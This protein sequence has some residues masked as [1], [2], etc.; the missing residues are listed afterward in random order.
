MA[1]ELAPHKAVIFIRAEVHEVLKGGEC[2]GDP[3]MKIGTFP[4]AISGKD[5]FEAERK[6]NELL[7]ELKTRCK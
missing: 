7:E 6:L 3:V 5:R 1:N 2:S 4:V